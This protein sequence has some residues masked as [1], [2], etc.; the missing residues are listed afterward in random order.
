MVKATN[1]FLLHSI[2]LSLVNSDIQLSFKHNLLE[3]ADR[4]G[5][6]NELLKEEHLAFCQLTGGL[7]IYAAVTVSELLGE[8]CPGAAGLPSRVT[9]DRRWRDKVQEGHYLGF[10][11]HVNPLTG[12]QGK[13][14]CRQSQDPFCPR[15]KPLFACGRYIFRL[16]H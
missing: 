2:K 13:R 16:A 12:N 8:H 3:L 9:R 7:L 6:V 10:V 11:I 5:I 14:R 4:Q 15:R 1:I